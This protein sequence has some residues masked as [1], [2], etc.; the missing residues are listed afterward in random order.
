MGQEI[1]LEILK[2]GEKYEINEAL[3]VFNIWTQRIWICLNH[4]ITGLDP[5]WSIHGDIESEAMR[6][7]FIKNNTAEKI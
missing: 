7:A 5:L 3:F 1:G 6:V 2:F 4:D